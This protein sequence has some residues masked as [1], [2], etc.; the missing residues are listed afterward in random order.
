MYILEDDI[1]EVTDENSV[2][3]YCSAHNI[4]L[5][6]FNLP[7]KIMDGVTSCARLLDGCISYNQYTIIPDSVTDCSAM[8]SDCRAFNQPVILPRNL[9]KA[10]SMF[11]GCYAFNQPVVLPNTLRVCTGM[12]FDCRSFNQY[13]FIPKKAA[14]KYSLFMDCISLKK[15]IVLSIPDKLINSSNGTIMLS[16]SKSH[17]YT[18]MF[19]NCPGKLDLQTFIYTADNDFD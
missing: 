7:I 10:G 14:V 16:S 15:S 9:E 6:D 1:L 13:I 17:M 19:D 11:A 12:F 2:K 5:T 18:Y 4:K 8:F 3:Q